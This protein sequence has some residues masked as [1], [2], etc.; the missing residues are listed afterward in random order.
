MP[1][2]SLD[3]VVDLISQRLSDISHATHQVCDHLFQVASHL[4]ETMHAIANIFYDL[5]L[6]TRYHDQD[7]QGKKSQDKVSP[8]DVSHNI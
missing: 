2:H 6:A 5:G 8:G 7:G 1:G 3:D 4:G